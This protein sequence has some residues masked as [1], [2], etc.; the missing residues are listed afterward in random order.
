MFFKLLKELPLMFIIAVIIWL[1]A[2]F[3]VVTIIR[4]KKQKTSSKKIITVIA[5]I[6]S[7]AALTAADIWIFVFFIPVHFKNNHL[8]QQAAT[9]ST[10]DITK[11]LQTADSNKTSSPTPAHV[12]SSKNKKDEII[13]AETKIYTTNQ[14]DITFLS[15]GEDEDIEA[16]N[17]NSVIAFNSSTGNFKVAALI[18]GFQFENQLMQ[19]HFN[20]PDYMNSDAYPNSE[21]KGKIM[22]LHQINFSINGAYDVDVTG[23]LTIHGITKNISTKGVFVISN[24]KISVQSTFKIKRIDFGI[25]TNEIADE[26]QITVK[27][28]LQ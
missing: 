17:P 19:S 21:F 2:L 13:K 9:I 16:H 18:K 15:Q 8:Q 4:S 20:D 25:T 10:T 5:T 1:A 3:V 28:T 23:S 6:L 14:A 27:G 12:D 11:E 7:A 26:L 22:N 24:K